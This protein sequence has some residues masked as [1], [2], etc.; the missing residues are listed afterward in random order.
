L[1]VTASF[2]PW[3]L[4]EVFGRVTP[5][6]VSLLTVNALVFIYLLMLVTS[7]QRRARESSESKK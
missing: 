6:R 3:E 1:V 2:L 7:R 5:V 4:F